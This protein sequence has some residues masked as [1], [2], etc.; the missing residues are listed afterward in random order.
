MTPL[1]RCGECGETWKAAEIVKGVTNDHSFTNEQH[2]PKCPTGQ[3]LKEQEGRT[4]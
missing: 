3:W 2:K 1:M 4:A